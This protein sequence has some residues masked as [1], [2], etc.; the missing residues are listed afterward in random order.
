MKGFFRKISPTGAVRDLVEQLSAPQPHRWRFLALALAATFTVFSLVTSE[1]HVGLPKL[2]DVTYFPS[3]LPGRSD[4]QIRAE[5]IEA[6]RKL[7]AEEAK[8]AA[9][10]A[11]VR[12]RYKVM[13]DSVGMSTQKVIDE[14][15]AQR[16][17][18][19]RKLDAQNAEI[20][21]KYLVP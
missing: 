21:R 7:R 8:E 19:K 4:A 12:R 1:E 10:D 20:L 17:A 16:I 11:E 13:G 14:G 18:A 6:T 9:D 15:E 3:L 2:P 5:N